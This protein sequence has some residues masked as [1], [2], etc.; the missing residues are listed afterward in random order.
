MF[1]TGLK[2]SCGS[3]LKVRCPSMHIN[4]QAFCYMIYV[5]TKCVLALS[6]PNILPHVFK[7]EPVFFCWAWGGGGGYDSILF[8][9]AESACAVFM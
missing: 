5:E 8:W 1:E 4:V 9:T 6:A 7:L 3:L 2:R